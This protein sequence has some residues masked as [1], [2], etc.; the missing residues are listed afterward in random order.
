M[1][2]SGR[3]FSP[4]QLSFTSGRQTDR[5]PL[6]PPNCA[7][8]EGNLAKF[9]GAPIGPGGGVA[10]GYIDT[11]A[12]R[13]LLEFDDPTQQKAGQLDFP[14]GPLE[15]GTGLVLNVKGKTKDQSGR[16]TS[17]GTVRITFT[18]RSS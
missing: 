8:F 14:L 6:R 3:S 5:Q 16:H 10:A 7:Y 15:A 4:A 12:V 1:L 18:P 13:F 9:A 2:L 11:R 17:E